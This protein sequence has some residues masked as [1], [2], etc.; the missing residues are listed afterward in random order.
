VGECFGRLVDWLNGV[1]DYGARL[2]RLEDVKA[3][4]LEICGDEGLAGKVLDRLFEVAEVRDGFLVY[5]PV[6]VLAAGLEE[7]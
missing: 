5:D 7:G 2:V 4:A 6:N 1:T 3:K